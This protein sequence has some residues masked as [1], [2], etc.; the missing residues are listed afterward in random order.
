MN[1][2][3]IQNKA[4][5]LARV[6]SNSQEE[7]GY[8]LDAQQKLLRNYCADQQYIIVKEFRVSETA[9]KNE[10]RTIFREMMTY[11][12]TGSASHL[13][14][15]KTDRLTRNFRDAIVVDDWLEANPQR[16][17]HMV[18]ESLIIHKNSRSSERMMW[19]IF[20]SLAKGRV[21]NLREEAMKGWSEK[22]AQGWRPS[23]PPIGYK[24][25]I[26]NGKK[27]H[28]VDEE[29][30]PLVER[31][32]RLY[33]E[34]D[35]N[36]KSVTK[37]ITESGLSSRRGRPLS[38]T[39]IHKMLREPF[40]GGIIR[41]NGSNYPGAHEPL[42]TRKLFKAVQNKLDGGYHEHRRTHNPLF[43]GELR[44]DA[45]GGIVTWQ[46][47]KG[48]YY[49]ACQ[50][51]NDACKKRKMIREDQLEDRVLTHID[52][53]D[54]S[55]TNS[56]LLRRLVDLFE[57]RRQ[58]YIGNHRETVMRAIRQ[59]IRRAEQMEDNLYE[60]KLA[61]VIDNQKYTQKLKELQDELTVLRSRLENLE[62][63]ETKQ[64]NIEKP[65]SIRELYL[66]ESKT[67]K[68]IIIHELFT[69]SM[70]GGAV[71]IDLKAK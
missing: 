53:L 39:A 6:S 16:R 37:E 17:L 36:I 11:L 61:G 54:S 47:Q 13:V 14:V 50:R 23:A 7:E 38:K 46:L 10:Q 24:T 33:L 21:D 67:G 15:E 49:G 9:A 32:F 58:P 30:A 68:R 41:F 4:V 1:V 12:S 28:V 70:L 56:R 48:R 42:I 55:H 8:S 29:T 35:Q 65:D 22:L 31:A 2:G 26:E 45:C 43:K 5:I 69:I 59:R 20:L 34:L 27:I 51:H 62:S 40:Y 52:E 71:C 66:R 25:A 44:C 3:K 60:D 18:K 64:P 19:N 63:L 57:A